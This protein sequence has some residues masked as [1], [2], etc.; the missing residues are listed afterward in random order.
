[1]PRLSEHEKRDRRIA[2]EI[3]ASTRLAACDLER[4]RAKSDYDRA[5]YAASKEAIKAKRRARYDAE[6]ERTY[7]AKNREAINAAKRL[8]YDAEKERE[9]RKAP[10]AKLY[11]TLWRQERREH[12][13]QY[14]Q[15]PARKLHNKQ[16]C[17]RYYAANRDAINAAR[18]AKRMAQ[19]R[20]REALRKPTRKISPAIARPYSV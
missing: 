20:E 9:Q 11:Q 19:R 8:A 12:L 17:A 15:S 13:R 10:E 4:R 18:R 16:N 1:M 5:R 3:A 2:R 6:K 7:R 14:E